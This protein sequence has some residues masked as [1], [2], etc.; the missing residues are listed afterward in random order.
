MSRVTIPQPSDFRIYLILP[1]Y[2]SSAWTEQKPLVKALGARYDPR[3]YRWW[4]D[5]RWPD[6]ARF[7]R[8]LPASAIPKPKPTPHTCPG[9]GTPIELHVNLCAA[10]REVHPTLRVRRR[11][12]PADR[13]LT[14]TNPVRFTVDGQGNVLTDRD[15]AAS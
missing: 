13:F 14:H 7:T 5:S 3:Q 11:R 12:N 2:G 10:C 6:L 4:V 8:W 15:R 1:K 9:C